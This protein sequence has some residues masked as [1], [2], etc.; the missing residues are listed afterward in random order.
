LFP[1]TCNRTFPL[2]SAFS[3]GVRARLVDD[4]P[5]VI[6]F[7]FAFISNGFKYR[8]LAIGADRVTGKAL[9]NSVK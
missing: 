2:I 9:A 1:V 8:L 6:H 7:S 3:E 5:T 4:Q